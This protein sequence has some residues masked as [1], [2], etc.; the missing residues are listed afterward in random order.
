MP[1]FQVL[2]VSQLCRYVKAVLEEQ[3]PL[4]DLMV[5]G[6][7]GDLSYRQSSGHL[8]FSIR[9]G[10][11]VVRC[12][13]FSRYVQ[14]LRQLP[15]E[16]AAVLVRGSAGLYER[17]GAFQLVANDLQP[18]GAGSGRLAMEAL[19][20]RL[21]AEGLLD[22][23]RKRPLPLLPEAIGVVTSRE[24]AALQDILRA[25][26]RRGYWGK[27][28][29]CHAAVQGPGAP[30]SLC[31]ALSS[32]MEEGE[33]Q[34]VLIARG[35]GS[36]EDLAAFNDE[37]LAR[38]AARCPVPVVSAVGHEVDYT[39]LDLVADARASTPTGAAELLVPDREALLGRVEGLRREAVRLARG[40]V[41][42]ERRRLGGAIALLSARS[43]KSRVEKNRQKLEYLV[44]LLRGAEE[45]R[46]RSLRGR[47]LSLLF[48]LEGL[49]PASVLRRGYSIAMA[50]GRVV[51]SAGELSPGDEL[52]TV[53]ADGRVVSTVRL[54]PGGEEKDGKE[55][56]P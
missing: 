15:E 51:S 35:G 11:A 31:R 18:L 13:M 47:A 53:F 49:N 17:D 23:K 27:L 56:K 40:R 22:E 55:G 30:D 44:R 34:A 4:S 38:L 48:R 42:E 10:G 43:P 28:I 6:E 7:L 9:D 21:E 39:L 36:R 50:G 19:V 8:Y 1:G 46:L 5:K 26:R 45:E 20:R 14:N 16:G 37:G 3:K 24:G 52:T 32:L 33:C 25:F 29:F 41:E 12:V 54:C 2:T